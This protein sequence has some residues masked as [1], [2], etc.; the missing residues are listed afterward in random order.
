MAVPEEKIDEAVR[1]LA[2]RREVS[3]CYRRTPY[4]DWPYNLYA[5][6]HGTSEEEMLRIAETFVREEGAGEH[7]ILFS[8]EELKKTSFSL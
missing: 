4:P 3:H 7:E 8:T 1:R 6:I 5:M 2:D